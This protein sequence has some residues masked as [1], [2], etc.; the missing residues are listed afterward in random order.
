MSSMPTSASAKAQLRSVA[1]RSMNARVSLERSTPT[2]SSIAKAKEICRKQARN[3]QRI[4]SATS[5]PIQWEAAASPCVVA[6]EQR[7]NAVKITIL[8]ASSR[9]VF[10]SAVTR[11][12]PRRSLTAQLQKPAPTPQLRGR[13]QVYPRRMQVHR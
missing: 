4:S 12:F 6:P 1:I 9:L 8:P 3:A 2:L 13:T 5:N 7:P 10:T 11:E